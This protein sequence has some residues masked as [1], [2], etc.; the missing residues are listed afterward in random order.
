VVSVLNTGTS[1]TNMHAHIRLGDI[2]AY[3]YAIHAKMTNILVTINELANCRTQ[4]KVA[5][6]S[7]LAVVYN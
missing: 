6:V 1:T 4:S 7:G 5:R 2:R 3:L